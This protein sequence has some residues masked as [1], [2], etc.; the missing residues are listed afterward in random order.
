MIKVI[1][2][3]LGND[4]RHEKGMLSIQVPFNNPNYYI[5]IPVDEM[6]KSIVKEPFVVEDKEKSTL[7]IF[8]V[9]DAV[10]CC[11]I[12]KDSYLY[13]ESTGDYIV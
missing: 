2:R 11:S 1:I 7:Y 10:P 6:K 3:Y 9:I 13:D 8:G 5:I 12:V 4:E